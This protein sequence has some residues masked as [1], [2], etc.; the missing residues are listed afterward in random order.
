MPYPKTSLESRK[1]QSSII[2]VFPSN[3]KSKKMCS[4]LCLPHPP[5]VFCG[6]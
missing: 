3:L 2:L 5:L 6:C 1:G 4:I